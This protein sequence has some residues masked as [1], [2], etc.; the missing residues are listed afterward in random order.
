M[1]FAWS[2]RYCVST[3]SPKASRVPRRLPSRPMGSHWIQR[4]SGKASSSAW[5]RV[6]SVGDVTVPVRM[7]SPAPR[8]AR[9]ASRTEASASTSPCQVRICPALVTTFERSGS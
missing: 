3:S 6:P 8:D 1:T 9:C 5:M 7:R 2:K 4:A